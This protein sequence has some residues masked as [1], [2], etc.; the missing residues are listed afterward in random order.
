MFRIAV[1]GFRRTS[2]CANTGAYV[3]LTAATI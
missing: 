1:S 2:P 3:R